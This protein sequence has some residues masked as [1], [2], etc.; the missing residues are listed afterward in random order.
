MVD[1]LLFGHVHAVFVWHHLSHAQRTSAGDDGDF[2][3]GVGSFQVPRGQCMAGFVISRSL[4]LFFGKNFLPFGTHQH[5]VVG[6]IEVF[7]FDFGFV[8]TRRPEG[9]FVDKVLDVG[10]C[11]ASGR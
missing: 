8:T 11:H 5:F 10:A 6:V 7:H 4:F 2:M 9:C 1:D 3:N